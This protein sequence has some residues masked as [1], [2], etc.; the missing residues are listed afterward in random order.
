MG[1]HDH[2]HEEHEADEITHRRRPRQ[3]H[4]QA[5]AEVQTGNRPS[6]LLIAGF[7][8]TKQTPCPLYL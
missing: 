6:L 4:R 2:Q 3:G 5:Q 1:A 7:S 8:V